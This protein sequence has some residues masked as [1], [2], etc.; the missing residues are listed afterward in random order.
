MGYYSGFLDSFG[1]LLVNAFLICLDFLITKSSNLY[2]G[3]VEGY[4]LYTSMKPK[5]I[6]NSLF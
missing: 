6:D 4:G 3:I 1:F 5:V 2:K